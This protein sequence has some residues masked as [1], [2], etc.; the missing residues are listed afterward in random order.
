[1]TTFASKLSNPLIR[2]LYDLWLDANV[3]NSPPTKAD[4]PIQDLPFKM[5]QY[6]FFCDYT[7]DKRFLCI[8]NGTAV[9]RFHGTEGTGKYMDEYLSE[10]FAKEV[11]PLYQG[12]MEGGS[13][14]YY[15]GDLPTGDESFMTYARLLLPIRSVH[16]DSNGHLLGI[17][18]K[19]GDHKTY[20]RP[21]QLKR[22]N[23]VWDSL[24]LQ[25]PLTRRKPL[26]R[27]TL[28]LF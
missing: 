27:G 12:V 1:M 7:P 26:D 4:F 6:L 19:T 13:A 16:D 17:M 28:G 23:I 21:I 20:T 9:V 18:I 5:W 15:E 22:R 25:K 2:G 8:H 24:D 10:D 11:L 14:V 3:D